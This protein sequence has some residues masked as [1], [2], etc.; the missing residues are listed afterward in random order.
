MVLEL[1]AQRQFKMVQ[2]DVKSAFIN[3]K[4][5][6]ELYIA[7]LGGFVTKD[8]EGKVMRLQNALYGFRKSPRS[9]NK[10]L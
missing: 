6:E 8:Q 1:A 3:G 9:W 10:I 4:L 7:Q 2:V 5:Q